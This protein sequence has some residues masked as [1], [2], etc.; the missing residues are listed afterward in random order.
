MI[1]AGQFNVSSAQV[2]A[3][4]ARGAQDIKTELWTAS[5]YD[6]FLTTETVVLVTTGNSVVDLPLDYD[7]EISLRVYDG[8]V[9]GR[10][11][12]GLSQQIT[13][14]SDESTD[15]QAYS[16]WYAFTLAGTGS[17]QYRQISRYTGATVIATV[18]VPWTTTPDSTTDYLVGSWWQPMKRADAVDFYA[19]NGR[20]TRYRVTGQQLTVWPPPD[21]VYPILIEY[22]PNLT[23]IDE[24]SSVFEKWLKYRR[25]LVTQGIKVQ[26]CL[27]HDTD[28]YEQQLAIWENMKARYGADGCQYDQV[29]GSR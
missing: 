10:A 23:M 28:R 4:A 8:D 29:D 15:D 13:L 20:P 9:R 2:L 21:K 17:A 5:R 11:Q 3:M 22:G 6:P 16:G 19:R 18:T 25:A 14:A 7:H 26:T 24:S 12:A 27:L 1:S